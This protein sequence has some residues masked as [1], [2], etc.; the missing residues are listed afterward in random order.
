MNLAV[1]LVSGAGVGLA[2]ATAVGLVDADA[3]GLEVDWVKLLSPF[4]HPVTKSGNEAASAA[5]SQRKTRLFICKSLTGKYRS[6]SRFLYYPIERLSYDSISSSKT[7]SCDSKNDFDESE[8]LAT[9]QLWL[10]T[11]NLHPATLI[12]RHLVYLRERRKNGQETDS[13]TRNGPAN[14]FSGGKEKL[15]SE[16]LID[17]RLGVHRLSLSR[18]SLNQSGNCCPISRPGS[19]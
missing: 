6:L 18:N 15:S 14:K 8:W 4:L 16:S 9:R 13:R 11:S 19:W 1:R 7:D 12:W 2:S 17:W 10:L 5:K 3:V